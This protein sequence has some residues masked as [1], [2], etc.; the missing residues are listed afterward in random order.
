MTEPFVSFD[1][2]TLL[3]NAKFNEPTSMQYE[4]YSGDLV[5]LD[6]FKSKC[7]SEMTEHIS[8]PTIEQAKEFLIKKT[9]KN[10]EVKHINESKICIIFGYQKILIKDYEYQELMNEIFETIL[11]K[12]IK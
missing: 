3:F 4:K 12:H 11:E 1:V 10:I 8:A 9:G 5:C 2:A 7:N 6:M